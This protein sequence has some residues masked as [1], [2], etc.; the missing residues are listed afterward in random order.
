ML[1]S[2]RS[3]IWMRFSPGD[4]L[5]A[6]RL[7]EEQAEL[8]L[9][10][11]VHPLQLLL[12]VQLHAVVGDLLGPAARPLAGGALLPGDGALGSLA[13]VSLEI[14]LVALAPAEPALG[15]DIPS[16]CLFLPTPAASSAAGT[17]YGVSG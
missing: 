3:S 16:H 8:P 13:P 10:H 1:S 5:V 11:A 6:H 14:E 17:R 4:A 9:Q 7:A 2:R 12:L 15:T